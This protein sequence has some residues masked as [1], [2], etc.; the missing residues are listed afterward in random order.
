MAAASNPSI[1]AIAEQAGVSHATVARVLGGRGIY[2][3]PADARRAERIRHLA[4]EL[5]YRPNAAA[6]ATASGRFGVIALLL[7]TVGERSNLPEPLLAGIHDALAERGLHL[8]VARLPDEK[9]IDT[10]FVPRILQETAADGLLIDYTHGVPDP[11]VELIGRHRL[12]AV[13]L[14]TKREDDAVY[15]D[16]TGLGRLATEHLLRLGHRRIGYLRHRMAHRPQTPT[17]YSLADRLDGYKAAMRDAG[18]EPM[19]RMP[20]PDRDLQNRWQLLDAWLRGP[21]RPTALLTYRSADAQTALFAAHGAGIRVPEDLSV[22]TLGTLVPHW[23]GDRWW[24]STAVAD[25]ASLGRE[26]VAMLERKIGEPDAA[27]RSVA[28]PGYIASA[29]NTCRALAAD[30]PPSGKEDESEAP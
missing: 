12:P 9:L 23:V 3:R 22:M 15:P 21:E 29:G 20:H 17:H 16:D 24:I 5:G 10:G 14:N 25:E 4:E 7:S 19:V 27:E 13:W 30:R 2:R 6:R 11:L 18:L 1:Y 26:A 28:I 8:T